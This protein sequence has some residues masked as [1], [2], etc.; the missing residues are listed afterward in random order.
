MPAV[1]QNVRS[2]SRVIDYPIRSRETAVLMVRPTYFDVL[3]EINPHMAGN[4]GT[5]DKT[6][7]EEQWNALKGTYETLGF[8]VHV[9][10][11]VEGLPDM[12][13]AANQTF[14]FVDST[15]QQRVILSKMASDLRQPEIVHFSRWYSKQQYDVIEQTVPPIEFEGMGDA[16][17]HPGRR[18]LYIG[19]GFRTNEGALQRAAKCIDCDVVGLEL[20]HPHFYHLDT[21][22]S[23]IDESTALYVHEAFTSDGV[24]MLQKMFA[25]LI[26]VPLIEAKE[27]FVTN[28][29][30]PDGKHFIVHKGNALTAAA[31]TNIGITVLEVDTSEFLKSGGSV[32]CMKM[33][34]P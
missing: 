1:H 21:A 8:P 28:G 14:P 12:V 25:R 27:G 24:A 3:Y 2:L 29:H 20:V 17:W 32:F 31:L 26:P 4:I 23:V 19:Y 6:L 18:L 34:L 16:I 10:E 11:G 9:I 30:S 22:L 5:V 7:A 15:G 33:M 13:F